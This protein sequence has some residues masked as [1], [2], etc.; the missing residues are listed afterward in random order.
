MQAGCTQIMKRLLFSSLLV[1]T[2]LPRAGV[3]ADALYLNI[4]TVSNP[5]VD[6]VRFV[7]KGLIQASGALPFETLDTL[8]FTNTVGTFSGSG[9]MLGTPGF[10]F[11]NSSSLTGMRTWSSSFF[12]DNGAVVQATDPRR[13]PFLLGCRVA[14]VGP[15]YLLVSATNIVV[16]AGTAGAPKASLI[17]GPNGTMEL[18]GKS[19][20]LNRS[21]LEVLPV[22]DEAQGS[23]TG[24]SNFA[25]DIAI[26]DLY[27]GRTNF[28]MDFPLFSGQL[29][30]GTIAIA[31]GA[32]F[33]LVL[34]FG[35]GGFALFGP[36]A[37]SYVNV[38]PQGFSKITITNQ[39]GST[40]DITFGTNI[41]KGAVFV[42][43]SPGMAVQIGFP[44]VAL[45]RSPLA[46]L[47]R[48]R[49]EDG[50]ERPDRPNPQGGPP[51]SR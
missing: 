26:S 36:E 46:I 23:R 44:G 14:S 15:S 38:L 31:Q 24:I 11:N 20:D 17:V 40:S 1:L 8:Y 37:D 3:A 35:G 13:D 47:H 39:N 32:P 48:V 4:G 7:N 49:P 10:R 41:T 19:L 45:Q 28:T 16:K 43:P 29:W 5:Q 42:G 27:W 2:L 50:A 6:A 30:D 51:E 33:P 34:P 18:T 25:P 22:W 9:A 21:G 12:N